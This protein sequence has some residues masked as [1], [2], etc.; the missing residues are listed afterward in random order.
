MLGCA[1][2]KP[3]KCARVAAKLDHS[4]WDH[5]SQTRGRSPRLA[6]SWQQ[7]GPQT[8]TRPQVVTQNPGDHGGHTGQ[9]HHCRLQSVHDHRPRHDLQKQPGP[10]HHHGPGER[11]KPVSGNLTSIQPVRHRMLL[12]RGMDKETATH[13]SSLFTREKV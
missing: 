4:C 1:Y 11:C 5:S 13:S 12:Y 7:H 3:R 8:R 6:W 9:S 10:G 2:T